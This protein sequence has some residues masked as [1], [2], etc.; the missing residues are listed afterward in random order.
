M[1]EQRSQRFL[2]IDR[3]KPNPQQPRRYFD[4]K[5]LQELSQSIKQQGI[6]QPLIVRNHPI[7]EGCFELVAG[8]RR[9]RALH[10]QESLKHRSLS[11]SWETQKPLRLSP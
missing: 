5:A 9:W 11:K 3:I 8:E 2:P 10:W 7:L 6:L 1:S 4:P